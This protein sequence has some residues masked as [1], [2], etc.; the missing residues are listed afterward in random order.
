SRKHEGIERYARLVHGHGSGHVQVM[1][2]GAILECDA[3]A[4]QK[5]GYFFDQRPNRSWV[6]SLCEG[7]AVLDLFAYVGAFAVQALKAG[8]A[9]VTS[10]DASQSALHWASRNVARLGAEN[11]WEAIRGDMP[12]VLH[13]L[14]QQKRRFDIVICD[15]P[16]FVKSRSKRQAGLRGYQ[17]LARSCAALVR[18]EGLLC[19]ASCSGLIDMDEFRLAT[20]KGIREAGRSAQIVHVGEAG[21]DHPWLPSMPE[22]RYLKFMAWRLD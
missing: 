4:G 12:R 13:D 11:R 19:A 7:R 18:A 5:T 17:G 3:L 16:A 6:G 15:P 8:A 9:H 20:L 14:G 22:T 1:E 21:A 2:N 10:V